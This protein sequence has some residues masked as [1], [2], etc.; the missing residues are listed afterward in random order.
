VEVEVADAMNNNAKGI[1][2]GAESKPKIIYIRDAISLSCCEQIMEL[3][4]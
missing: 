4:Q 3:L 2:H 1:A